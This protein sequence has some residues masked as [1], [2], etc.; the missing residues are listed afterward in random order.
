MRRWPWFPVWRGWRRAR[1]GAWLPGG[2]WRGSAA[3]G[4]GGWDR[5]RVRRSGWRRP[6]CARGGRG[7]RG[8]GWVGGVLPGLL[9]AG[10]V[11][12]FAF[13]GG[14]D[15]LGLADELGADRA[16]LL[17]RIKGDRVFSRDPPAREPGGR[18]RPRRHG[19]RFDC[20]KPDTWG[21]PAAQLTAPDGP[22]GTV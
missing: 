19:A 17:V 4:A 3:G 6:W 10:G 8:G 15:P 16:Q 14:Y 22:Y 9:P 5:G 2:G 1:G 11:P 12:L 18:G 20:K 21:T 7:C 13:D